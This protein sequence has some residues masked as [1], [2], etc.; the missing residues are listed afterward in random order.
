MN[1]NE[2]PSRSLRPRGA[3]LARHRSTDTIDDCAGD[4]A[5]SF[6]ESLSI[7]VIRF[8]LQ[9]NADGAAQTLLENAA[10]DRR[11][12]A[13]VLILRQN[14]KPGD[15]EVVWRGDQSSPSDVDSIDHDHIRRTARGHGRDPKLANV[16][17]APDFGRRATVRSFRDTEA[18]LRLD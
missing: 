13:A 16:A 6:I 5:E 12:D 10:H 18:T 8:N 3:W 14:L 9:H 2:V 1:P 17:F 7:G 4:E 15:L 11:A